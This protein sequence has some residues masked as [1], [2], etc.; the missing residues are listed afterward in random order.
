MPRRRSKHERPEY[1][2]MFRVF[3]AEE[4]AAIRSIAIAYRV[5]VAEAIRMLVTWGLESE[6]HEVRNRPPSSHVS[7]PSHN[8]LGHSRKQD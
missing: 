3:D 8:G 1:R 4:M 2:L 5:S 6:V 7:P